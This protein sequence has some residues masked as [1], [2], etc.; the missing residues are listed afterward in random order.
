MKT[1]T[2]KTLLTIGAIC[3]ALHLYFPTGFTRRPCSS[4]ISVKII[5]SL[6]LAH[7]Y[8]ETYATGR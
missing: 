2:F 1:H 8:S 3:L 6:S 5:D 7:K 4:E